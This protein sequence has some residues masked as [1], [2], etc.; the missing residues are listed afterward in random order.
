MMSKPFRASEPWMKT[1]TRICWPTGPANTGAGDG[2][3]VAEPVAVDGSARQTSPV[4][5]WANGIMLFEEAT[6]AR[7]RMAGTKRRMSGLFKQNRL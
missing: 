2:Q 6:T 3:G 5:A 1:P 4:A 7:R